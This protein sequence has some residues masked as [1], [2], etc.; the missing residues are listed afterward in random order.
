MPMVNQA[1][2]SKIGA[3]QRSVMPMGPDGLIGDSPQLQTTRQRALQ[4]IQ[5]SKANARTYIGQEAG[6]FAARYR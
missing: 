6:L 5:S 2:Q 3:Q 4:A 1:L